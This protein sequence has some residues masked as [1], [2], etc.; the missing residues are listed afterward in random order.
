MGIAFRDGWIGLQGHGVLRSLP[1]HQ[2]GGHP[3]GGVL[4]VILVSGYVGDAAVAPSNTGWADEVLTKPLRA[5]A[6]GT[7]LA[8]V[9]D[10]A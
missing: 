8:R 6:L 2:S 1:S 4:S 10:I 3:L 7:S 5:N 9:L